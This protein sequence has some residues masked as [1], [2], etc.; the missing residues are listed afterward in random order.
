ME[1]FSNSVILPEDLPELQPSPF[2]GLDR[3]Y[4]IILYIRIALVFLFL[5]AGFVAFL[6]FAEGNFPTA[7]TYALAAGILLVVAF[8]TVV[9]VLGFPRKGYLVRERDVSYQRGLITYRV[10]S[11]PLNRIQHVELSQG[12]LAKLL[13]LSAVKIYTAG[14]TSSDLSIPGL[15]T[16]EAAKLKAHLSEKV[17]EHE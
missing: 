7:V 13:D 2:Q 1:N 6:L 14:G 17:N 11:V 8:M 3:K 15:K 9:A 10:T 16:E 12:V 5:T 4:L